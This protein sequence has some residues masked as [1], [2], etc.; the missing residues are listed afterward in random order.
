MSKDLIIDRKA[1]SLALQKVL[2]DQHLS[3]KELADSISVNEKNLEKWT[4]NQ[5]KVMPN[6]EELDRFCE[7]YNIDEESLIKKEV[8]P[9][10]AENKQKEKE[11]IDKGD[12]YYVY[13]NSHFLSHK[14]FG[15]I[16]SLVIAGVI[17]AQSSIT[18]YL[19][20]FWSV[21]SIFNL[22][23]ALIFLS[24]IV[25]LLFLK[26]RVKL[27]TLNKTMI[28]HLIHLD[29]KLQVSTMKV[30]F[31]FNVIVILN[32]LFSVTDL[33]SLFTQETTKGNQLIYVVITLAVVSLI[34][35][36]ALIKVMSII[37]K[38]YDRVAISY[39]GEEKV[40]ILQSSQFK[41]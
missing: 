19:D 37:V 22:L 13:N 11:L 35:G 7:K 25:S 36:I 16:L 17:I 20:H 28:A 9:T 29:D 38:N 39:N 15:I 12:K 26:S 34:L 21:P 8:K 27:N 32:L 3:I 24:T 5:A 10:A 30:S 14:L 41:K 40:Y 1:L 18:I 4:L 33:F 6:K 31:R 23:T 2:K